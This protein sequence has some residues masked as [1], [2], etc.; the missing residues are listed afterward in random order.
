MAGNSFKCQCAGVS[1]VQ[2]K[3]LERS[4]VIGNQNGEGLI[5][6]FATEGKVDVGE[7]ARIVGDV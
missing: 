1:A 3:R 6:E 4:A 7:I 5:R 2:T